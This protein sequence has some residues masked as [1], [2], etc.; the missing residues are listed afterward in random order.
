MQAQPLPLDSAAPDP[1]ARLDRLHL[2]FGWWALGL[3]LLGGLALESLHAFK[4][5]WYLDAANETRR[6][7]LTLAHAHGVLLALVNVGFGASVARVPSA[8]ATLLRIASP[9]LRAAT[10]L[11]PGGFLLGG[12][13][14]YGGDPGVGIVLVPI[15]ALVLLAGVVATAL[16]HGRR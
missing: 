12:L 1:H 9:C 16:A 7:L 13:V 14:I 2:R 11:L 3:F 4:S 5:R 10:L 15:G 6:M 8:G